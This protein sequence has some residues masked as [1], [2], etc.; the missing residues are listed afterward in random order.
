MRRLTIFDAIAAGR[1]NTSQADSLLNLPE[2][3]PDAK[4]IGYAES[5]TCRGV[6]DAVNDFLA[7]MARDREFTRRRGWGP[8]W[9]RPWK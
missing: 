9:S 3:V 4:W 1:I 2:S 7:L 6:E 5:R 8:P